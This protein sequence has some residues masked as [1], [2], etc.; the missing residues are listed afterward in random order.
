MNVN[1]D[2]GNLYKATALWLSSH[3]EYLDRITCD[4]RGG[5]ARW[6]RRPQN[7]PTKGVVPWREA[8]GRYFYWTR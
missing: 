4:G 3:K 2:V 6:G 5:R 1:K 8:K 7:Y